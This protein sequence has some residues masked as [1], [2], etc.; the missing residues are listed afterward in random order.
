MRPEGAI[1]YAGWAV[2][3]ATGSLLLAGATMVGLFVARHPGALPAHAVAQVLYDIPLALA[4][5]VVST[6]ILRRL[7]THPIGWLFGLVGVAV[8]FGLSTEGFAAWGPPGTRWLVWTRTLL[9]GPTFFGLAMALLLFPTGAPASPRWRLLARLLW[10][11]VGAAV[12]VG[13]VAPWPR[14]DDL[15]VM[16]VQERAGAPARN[17]VGWVGQAWLSDAATLVVPAGVA[18][19][20]AAGLSLLPRWRRS[21]GD[22]RQQIKWLGLAGLL[23]ALELTGGLVQTLT[24]GMPQDDPVA[25]LVGSAVFLILVAAI[26]VA[27]GLGI[28]RYRLYDIDVIVSR[29]LV[30]GGLAVF[31]A[32]AYV[33]GVV[34]AG[35]LVD[36]WAGSSTLLALTATAGVAAAFHPLRTWLQG[37]ADRWV[38][39][40]R[41]A[42]YEV[43]SRFGHE[44]GQSLAP[45]DV[46][47][48]IAE[49]AGQ[50]VRAG[51]ARVTA[52]LLSGETLTA[53]WPADGP[54]R[55]YD[56]VVPVHH[57]GALVAEISVAAAEPRAADV[58][59][60]HRTAAVSAG[61]LRNLR[62]LAELE[63][64][65]ATIQRQNQELAA[66]RNRIAAAARQER[67]RLERE[68][69]QRVGPHL[70]VLRDGLPRLQCE[71]GARPDRVVSGCAGLAAHAT[72]VVD[73]MRALSRG[74]LP[75]LLV[76]HGLAAALRALL[77]RH[78]GDVTLHMAPS[79][80]APR[81]PAHVETTAYLCCR[82]AVEAA[83]A[84][85]HDVAHADLRLWRDNGALAFSVTHSAP[86]AADGDLAALRDRVSTLGGEL[87]T[88]PPGQWSTLT[89]TLPLEPGLDRI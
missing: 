36:R 34:A 1:R 54:P 18:L 16:A 42:P 53:C 41:A 77:R 73:G 32:L 85:G 30:Y 26:P 5:A 51:A 29:T 76:D 60:L 27:I 58:T 33:V 88:S 7:P 39:G 19:L 84:P 21:T 22:E 72:A 80:D 89:G 78:E 67:Q 47:A 83:A 40:R 23:A 48:R 44:L 49:T 71:V 56:L 46:L 28:V 66:S 9:T 61:A 12:L 59:L 74:V 11:Y 38:F 68:I 81:L 10:V 65:H 69:A 4:F 31:I 63:S 64:L 13:A 82:A 17:P 8:A 37:R 2:A 20:L 55:A 35:E 86:R 79:L 87:V 3:A 52:T 70:E 45:H 75:P 50:A 62:L 57:E 14:M 6:A 15:L 24:V 43:M 25:E